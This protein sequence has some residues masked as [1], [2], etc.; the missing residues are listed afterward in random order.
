MNT[1]T[2]CNGDLKLPDSL[3]LIILVTKCDKLQ[4]KK[5]PN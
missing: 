2:V 3:Q 1:S 5:S 4:N